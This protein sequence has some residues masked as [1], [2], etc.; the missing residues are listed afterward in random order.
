MS[1]QKRL[2]ESRIRGLDEAKTDFAV[3]ATASGMLIKAFPKEEQA[4]M[5]IKNKYSQRKNLR[6]NLGIVEVPK[7]RAPGNNMKKYGDIKVVKESVELDEG[8]FDYDPR[9]KKMSK[10]GKEI[11]AHMTNSYETATH[12]DFIDHNNVHTLPKSVVQKTLT[13]ASKE[14][15]LPAKQK[16]ELAL[17]KKEL[18]ESVELD[19]VRKD[20]PHF[21]KSGR[22]HKEV[23]AELKKVMDS[24]YYREFRASNG[25]RAL[26][27][28]INH[29]GKSRGWRVDK[30]VKSIIGKYGKNRDE[31]VKLSFQSAA[32]GRMNEDVELDEAKTVTLIAKKG[33]KKIETVKKVTPKERKTVEMLLRTAHGKD[34]TIEVVKESVELDEASEKQMIDMLRKEYGKISK[35]DPSSPT[36]KKLTGL[37]DNLAKN[38]PSL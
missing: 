38:N 4:R 11:L 30:T 12:D 36:Y 17:I 2:Y 1:I 10:K 23:H 32:K 14:R 37:L 27:N 9:I 6:G 16:K 34:I 33:S 28:V 29:M 5:Y 7:S 31:Y 3:V 35:V 26:E 24:K 21:L 13:M 25:G 15:N 20:D 22:F 18:G 19:E 8:K